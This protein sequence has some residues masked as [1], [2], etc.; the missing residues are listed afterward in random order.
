MKVGREPTYISIVEK[1]LRTTDDIIHQESIT[2][3]TGL[4][5]KQVAISLWYLEKIGVAVREEG[6]FYFALP[7]EFDQR[8]KKVK[9]TLHGTT[10]KRKIKPKVPRQ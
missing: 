5:H 6:N 2:C 1:F 10:R 8:K 9:E 7:P 4:T 3:G